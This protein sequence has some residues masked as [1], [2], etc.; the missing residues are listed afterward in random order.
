MPSS[1]ESE[2]AAP[3]QDGGDQAQGQTQTQTQTA[4]RGTARAQAPDRE[5]A[6]REAAEREAQLEDLYKRALADLDNYRKRTA[7]EIERRVAEG[8]ES[9]IADWLEVVDTVERALRMEPPDSPTYGAFR[10]LH[11]QVDSVLA[12]QGVVRIGAVGEQFD[13]ERHEA[14]GV[15][16][17]DDVADRTVVEVAR[18]GFALGDRILRPAQVLVARRPEA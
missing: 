16:P 1:P 4:E 10:A 2:G 7:R 18:S 9:I 15:V 14:I 6:E 12:R 5:S 8:R 13:P 11:E 17:R 3:P